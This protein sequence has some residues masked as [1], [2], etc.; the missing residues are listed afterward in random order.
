MMPRLPGLKKN[1]NGDVIE[2]GNM[3]SSLPGFRLFMALKRFIF[4][5]Q[6]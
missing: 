6:K 4:R 1:S 5:M 2:A 3:L